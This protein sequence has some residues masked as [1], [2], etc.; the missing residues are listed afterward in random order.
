LD[1]ASAG[2]NINIYFNNGNDTVCQVAFL[3][4]Y[5]PV[6]QNNGASYYP[7]HSIDN[8]QG[9]PNVFNYTVENGFVNITAGADTNNINVTLNEN[10]R[11]NITAYSYF[12]DITI[13]LPAGANPIQLSN[14]KSQVGTVKIL[15]S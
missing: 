15:N 9:R 7:R 5:G 6:V 8:V 3:Q 13:H 10:F 4:P 14:L 2:D 12:G 1:V 11:A